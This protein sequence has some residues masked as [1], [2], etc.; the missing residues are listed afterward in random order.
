MFLVPIRSHCY[1]YMYTYTIKRIT[2]HAKSKVTFVMLLN[3]IYYNQNGLNYNWHNVYLDTI[4]AEA[5]LRLPN[6]HKC[7]NTVVFICHAIMTATAFMRPSGNATI[8]RKYYK[9][10]DIVHD[11]RAKISTL[12][13]KNGRF[14]IC[15]R[16]VVL[17]R[18]VGCSLAN[19]R[20]RRRDKIVVAVFSAASDTLY[21]RVPCTYA[22][23]AEMDRHRVAGV[24]YA[25]K[26]L[27]TRH[28]GCDHFKRR[29]IRVA[30]GGRDTG[31]RAD[32]TAVK[33]RRIASVDL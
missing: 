33:G 25:C 22:A 26:S 20:F 1:G 19:G 5:V 23:A 24:S 27:A 18:G 16:L 10:Y 8:V 29:R 7:R 2:C 31:R 3:T 28:T 9:D 13:F 14:I 12:F 6:I 30:A 21:I 11:Q 15:L 17:R 32:R 4:K